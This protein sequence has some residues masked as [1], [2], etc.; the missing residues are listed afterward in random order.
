MTFSYSNTLLTSRDKVRFRIGDTVSTFTPQLADEEIDAIVTANPSF[1]EA[2]AI[3]AESL[4]AQFMRQATSK[5]AATMKVDYSGRIDNL[6]K[7]AEL[8]RSGAEAIGLAEIILTGT[9][10]TELAETA[11]DTT[12]L[13]PAFVRGQFDNL[14]ALASTQLEVEA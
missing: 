3:C 7:L 2:M 8:L 4:A 11:A 12:L 14:G 5:Q 9:T 1:P 6:L 13:Q 10:V